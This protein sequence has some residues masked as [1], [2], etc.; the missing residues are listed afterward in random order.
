MSG[1]LSTWASDGDIG[2]FPSS[3]VGPAGRRQNCRAKLCIA[4]LHPTAHHLCSTACSRRVQ[5]IN[6]LL[7]VASLARRAEGKIRLTRLTLPKESPSHSSRL[8]F[9]AARTIPRK[10]RPGE[11]WDLGPRPSIVAQQAAGIR[12][13]RRSCRPALMSRFLLIAPRLASISQCLAALCTP[14]SARSPTEASDSW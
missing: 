13:R 14:G 6:L 2:S 8:F 12:L 5:S 4:P 7:T 11:T 3:I 10:T 1:G 9:A